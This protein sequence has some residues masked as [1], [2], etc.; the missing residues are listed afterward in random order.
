[1]AAGQ[2]A[3]KPKKAFQNNKLVLP[4]AAGQMAEDE[5]GASQCAAADATAPAAMRAWADHAAHLDLAI[6]E[7]SALAGAFEQAKQCKSRPGESRIAG[8]SDSG[9]AQSKRGYGDEEKGES[10]KTRQDI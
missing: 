7:K 2:S 4:R 1:L 9:A 3:L 6:A 8:L 10:C 5:Q